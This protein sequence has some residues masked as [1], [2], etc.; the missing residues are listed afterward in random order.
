MCSLLC[1]Q[2]ELTAKSLREHM[3]PGGAHG[4]NVDI[5]HTS[6]VF[7]STA[8]RGSESGLMG[9]VVLC[10]LLGPEGPERLLPLGGG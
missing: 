6:R 7:A 3:F 10:T 9:W 2:G 8:L 4:W 1:I 5:G